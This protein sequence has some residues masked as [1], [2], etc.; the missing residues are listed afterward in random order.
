M[1][2]RKDLQRLHFEKKTKRNTKVVEGI[3]TILGFYI[4][5]AVT[6]SFAVTTLQSLHA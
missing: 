5:P 6:F 3:Q 1:L 2:T 4:Y